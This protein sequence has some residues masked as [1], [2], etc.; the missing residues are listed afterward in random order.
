MAITDWYTVKDNQDQGGA[1]ILNIYHVVK[2][3]PAFLAADIAEAFEDTMF[4]SL[5][6]EQHETLTHSLIEVENWIE[7]TDFATRVPSPNVG[8]RVGN[9]FSQFNACTIQFN[10]KRTAMNSGQ[11]R[12]AVGN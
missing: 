10:R 1:N 7:P 11:N 8:V 3:N 2:L 12:F 9:A 5:L 4:T 6:N